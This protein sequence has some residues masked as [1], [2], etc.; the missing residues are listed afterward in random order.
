MCETINPETLISLVEERPVLWDKTLDIYKDKHLKLPASPHKIF[1]LQLGVPNI[2]S[3]FYYVS[4]GD[5]NTES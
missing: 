2:L 5:T 1:V 3:Y 4:D